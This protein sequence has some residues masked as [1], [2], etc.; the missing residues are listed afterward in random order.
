MSVKRIFISCLLGI[1]TLVVINYF[2]FVDTS[3][4]VNYAHPQHPPPNPINISYSYQ[5]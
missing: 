2:I 5:P 4:S 1:S 3:T